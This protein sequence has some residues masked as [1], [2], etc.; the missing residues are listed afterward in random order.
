MTTPIINLQNI[1]FRL[2]EQKKEIL[3][4]ITY[5]VNEGDFVIILGSNGS[6]KSSLLKLIDKR[7][8]PSSGK[9]LL[10]GHLLSQYSPKNFVS[11][12]KTL[13]QN[14]QESLFTSLTVFENYELFKKYASPSKN[15]PH[16]PKRDDCQLYLSQFNKKI[17]RNL[18]QVVD[19]LSGGEKQMLAL[20][21][22]MLSPPA[23]L[24][25]DEHTSALD[26][27][28]SEAIMALTQELL[29]KFQVTC[30]LTTHDLKKA[31][32]YGN[33]LITL[34]DGKIVKTLESHEKKTMTPELLLRL[35]TE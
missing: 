14:Y 3:S 11:Q 20:A 30:L 7:Y 17:S 8:T 5:Q 6:G 35:F 19:K 22:I 9:I 29:K 21:L 13:T 4:A 2:P 33:R 10:K 28:S 31:A 34:R 12:V 18:D 27:A 25:L 23:L 16:H 15:A 26:P 24:L 32:A 1:S